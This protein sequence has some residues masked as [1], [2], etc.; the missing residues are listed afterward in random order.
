MLLHAGDFTR[1][2]EHEGVEDLGKYFGGLLAGD[3]G[4]GPV[5]EV[6]CIAGNHDITFQPETYAEN[7]KTFFYRAG[8]PFDTAVTERLLGDCTYLRDELLKSSG[9][10]NDGY[11]GLVPFFEGCRPMVRGED[12]VVDGVSFG[13]IRC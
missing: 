3:G 10:R 12:L 6:V 4:D 9:D 11:G 8:G 5:G 1:A 13:D 2:G 7:W